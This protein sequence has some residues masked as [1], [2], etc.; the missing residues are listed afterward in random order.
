M[1]CSFVADIIAFNHDL[2]KIKS[3][4]KTGWTDD[5]FTTFAYPTNNENC[6]IRRTGFDFDKT[7]ATRG[8]AE[9]WKKK[10]IEVAERGGAIAHAYIGTA[11]SAILARP[12]NIPNQQAHL[13]GTS[14]GGKTALQKFTASIFGN[15]RELI[16]TFAATN[17][18]RQLVAA[19]FCDLPSF[20]DEL[21]TVQS[22]AAEET[23]ANDVYNFADGRGNQA[24]KRDGTARETFK[25]GGARLTTGER[26]ILKQH[27]LRGAY[28]RI[29]QL[30]VHGNLFDD[31][32][33]TDL[34]IFSDSNFGHFGYQWIQFATAHM[35]EIQAKY[36]HF[37]KSDPTTKN[38]EP[39]QLK[40][41]AAS[42]VA[43]EFF[44][45]MLGVTDTFD[46]VNLIRDRR[47]LLNTQLPTLKDLDDTAR[48]EEALTSFV[49]SHEKY[50]LRN[51]KDTNG[52]EMT[53][54]FANETY[55]KIFD[56]GEVTFFPT[57]LKKILEDELKF[58]SYDKLIAAWLE[59]GKLVTSS[60]RKDNTIRIAKKT[61]KVIHFR[62]NIIA[63]DIDSA[64]TSYYERLG[65]V[66]S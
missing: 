25:F 39:T 63:T 31:E 62:A 59:Q 35:A 42:L 32:F 23:L 10:F 57:A 21:E 1:F 2:P 28:K 15:P 13:Q 27:D 66:D 52:D 12:L 55:G 51:Q 29:I 33:A 24:N 30:D 11:L 18:N 22:K 6:I 56:T 58:A 54:T 50:F 20:Y 19:A 40:M 44:K 65:V 7:L 41:L 38:Y 53:F 47:E 36:Q 45:V 49:A 17:K 37:A 46:S 48:A 61:Y 34:W 14:G 9:E 43:F 64:E 26:P 3:Y 5:N 60:G 8:N 4:N 16:R